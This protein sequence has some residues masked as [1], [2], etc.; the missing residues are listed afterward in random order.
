MHQGSS[1]CSWFYSAD[2]CSPRMKHRPFDKLM[3][4][5]SPFCHKVLSCFKDNSKQSICSKHVVVVFLFYFFFI[6][7]FVVSLF[8]LFFFFLQIHLFLKCPNI[9]S[10]DNFTT[11]SS[12]LITVFSWQISKLGSHLADGTAKSKFGSF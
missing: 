11:W 2:H 8:V 7:L 4:C 6:L 10:L 9:N 12:G 5:N 3:E 1:L